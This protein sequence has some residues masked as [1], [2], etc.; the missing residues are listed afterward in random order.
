[1]SHRRRKFDCGTAFA[2]GTAFATQGGVQRL[3]S[4][5]TYFAW[6]VAVGLFADIGCTGKAPSTHDDPWAHVPKPPK[7]LDHGPFYNEPCDDASA[8]TKSCLK[9]HPNAAKD[10][11]AT[12]HWT[13][14][15]EH[16]HVPGHDEDIQIGKA[17]LINNFCIGVQPNIESC[18]SCHTGYGWTDANF[19]FGDESLVD[20][21]VC[22]DQSGTYAKTK[23]GFPAQGVDL[24]QVAKS[25]GRPTRANCGACHFDGGGGDAVKHGDLDRTLIFPTERIDVHMGRYDFACVDCHRTPNHDI[26][27]RSMSVGV[28]DSHRVYCTDCHSPTPHNDERIDGHT[29]TVACMTCHMPKMAIETP[30]KMRWDWSTAGQERPDE[31]PHHYLKK[32]GTFE[33]AAQV[34][35]EYD[36]YNGLS[37]RYL[38][39][40][41]VLPAGVN[42]INEPLGDIRDPTAKIWPF[43]VH[44][45]KQIYDAK[46]GYFMV[47]KTVGKGGYWT[48]FDWDQALELGAKTT[49]LAYSGEYA[50]AET[51]MYWPLAH[52]VPPKQESLRC[53]DCHGDEGRFDWQAL[54]Y[55]GDPA[56]R[57]SR[58]SLGYV[59]STRDRGEP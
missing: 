37:K 24:L 32:K 17:N 53:G 48:E 44:R 40:D 29:E 13:W 46:N 7:H 33:Y 22:H 25:V 27:G 11:M 4:R 30:T 26:Q 15:G 20:C 21:L 38:L 18:S 45:G 52:M 14:K 49:G 57:G 3:T 50:F 41:P 51:R 31:D 12:S 42:A 1:M 56:E 35:P 39:G 59:G 36:W 6:M 58:R 34:E 28:D 2:K 55:P 23:G 43:K 9:C 19:D 47:P 10:V 16:V 5:G 54:G 8:V